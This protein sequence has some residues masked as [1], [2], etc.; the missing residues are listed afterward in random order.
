MNDVNKTRIELTYQYLCKADAV[1]ML[2]AADQMLSI[3]EVEFL[4]ERILSRQ[5]KDVFYIINRKDT[6]SGPEEESKVIAFAK[7]NLEEIIPSELSG[8]L[9]IFLLSSYQA[10]LFRRQENGDELTAK[11]LTKIP[12]DFADTG[13]PEFEKSWLNAKCCGI[14]DS[15]HT[16]HGLNP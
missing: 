8:E 2:L 13:F 15:A 4:R 3:S 5:I 16:T 7:R 1:V 12:M 9:R 6:L 11:Q 10:L 14:L